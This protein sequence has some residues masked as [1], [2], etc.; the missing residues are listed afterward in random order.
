[1]LLCLSILLP[2]FNNN[3]TDIIHIVIQKSYYWTK[4]IPV[5]SDANTVF[6]LQDASGNN[7][8]RLGQSSGNL[9]CYYYSAGVEQTGASY[10]ATVNTR[11]RL[12]L[13]YDVTNHLYSC[14]ISDYNDSLLWITS[15]ALSGSHRN[16]VQNY[17][18]SISGAYSQ[19]YDNFSIDTNM[20]PLRSS[21]FTYQTNK[22]FPKAD[23]ST[24]WA[25]VGCT[26]HYDCLDN[27]PYDDSKY[28]WVSA[29]T[30][31]SEDRFSITTSKSD[32]PTQK[33]RILGVQLWI[34]GK[35]YGASYR[36]AERILPRIR[37]H[38]TNYDEGIILSS[39]LHPT[40]WSYLVDEY[41]KVCAEEAFTDEDCY[42]RAFADRNFETGLPWT[43]DEIQ[44]AQISV[45]SP[46]G[47][48]GAFKNGGQVSQMYLRVIQGKPDQVYID[49]TTPVFSNVTTSGVSIFVKA[50]RPVDENMSVKL[51]VKY[52]KGTGT[53]PACTPTTESTPV[54]VTHT[55][56][57]ATQVAI[58]GLDAGATY[59]FDFFAS[60][61][62]GSTYTSRYDLFGQYAAVKVNDTTGNLKGMAVS[63]VH[64]SSGNLRGPLEAEAFGVNYLLSLGD[65]IDDINGQKWDAY[66][67]YRFRFGYSGGYLPRI[68]LFDKMGFWNIPDDHDYCCNNPDK[69]YKTAFDVGKDAFLHWEPAGTPPSENS[70]WA[71]GLWRNFTLGDNTCVYFIDTRYNRDPDN[72]PTGQYGGDLLDGCRT[73]ASGTPNAANVT[74][75]VTSIDSSGCDG[76]VNCKI[77]V[78]G[79]TFLNGDSTHRAYVGDLVKDSGTNYGV[80]REVIDNT[81]LRIW[82][83]ATLPHGADVA[84]F[85]ASE[86]FSIYESGGSDPGRYADFGGSFCQHRQRNW[87]KGHLQGDSCF[88]KLVMSTIVLNRTEMHD[89]TAHD[90]WGDFD[91]VQAQRQ[92]IV[93]LQADP[94][95]SK[96]IWT[97][98]DV[99]GAGVD[100]GSYSDYIE[101]WEAPWMLDG[102]ANSYGAWSH[103]YYAQSFPW[104][105]ATVYNPS[106]AYSKDYMVSNT[107]G[108]N[109][110]VETSTLGTYD[111]TNYPPVIYGGT[112][113]DS[114]TLT[115]LASPHNTIALQ[116]LKLVM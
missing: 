57:W 49:S 61:D 82:N 10:A 99:H 108:W 112:I 63:D 96:I 87:F 40:E 44:N 59:I 31:S 111:E 62:G 35:G 68:N 36:E 105:S 48:T 79:A 114:W 55:E 72:E 89:P 91:P 51:K 4:V 70:G 7:A 22:M 37:T 98:G 102:N 90:T 17:A 104:Q 56:D 38:A 47:Y 50:A 86:A 27:D 11:Y 34:R 3:S 29:P 20:A 1:M 19:Y 76:G 77:Y 103:Y 9:T 18:V 30:S 54:T 93:N 73:N 52:C 84:I 21:A 109:S 116:V 64:N 78:S 65:L 32:L 88:W 25:S 12:D 81:H 5:S 97:T 107:Y 16:G 113:D 60:G 74:G 58:T 6:A 101:V 42:R 23:V 26:N 71:Y 53:P 69:T 106:S 95:H 110:W 33:G 41:A 28:I 92:Y 80:I 39:K 8:V 13:S 46:E 75:T 15:G 66:A 83:P 85:S 45:V 2:H 94:A 43:W 100:N 14:A 67:S 115:V 24:Q